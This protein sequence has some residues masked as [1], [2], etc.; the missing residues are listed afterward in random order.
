LHA[1]RD[2]RK[3]WTSAKSGMRLE[4]NANKGFYGVATAARVRRR[5]Q[6]MV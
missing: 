3:Q 6:R 1:S 4:T 5:A 2:A